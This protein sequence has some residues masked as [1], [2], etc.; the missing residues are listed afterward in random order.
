M[1][2]QRLT[3]KQYNTLCDWTLNYLNKNTYKMYKFARSHQIF[4]ELLWY[5]L[6]QAHQQDPEIHFFEDFSD[7]LVFLN[8]FFTLCKKSIYYKENY[9]NYGTDFIGT[10]FDWNEPLNKFLEERKFMF[11]SQTNLNSN[12]RL[13]GTAET[14]MRTV[15]DIASLDE[16]SVLTDFPKQLFQKENFSEF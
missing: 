4:V 9:A 11:Y 12:L 2:Y 8:H 3:K 7:L 5:D 16:N 10:V 15:Y 13:F 14:N 1:T 6:Y